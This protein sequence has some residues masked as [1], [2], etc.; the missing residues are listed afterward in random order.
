MLFSLHNF[1]N[2]RS[3]FGL[4]SLIFLA[5]F[6][7]AFGGAPASLAAQSTPGLASRLAKQYRATGAHF[8]RAENLLS[9]QTASREERDAVLAA[10][11]AALLPAVHPALWEYSHSVAAADAFLKLSGEHKI[12]NWMLDPVLYFGG[13]AH[14][15]LRNYVRAAELFARLSPDY[16]RDVYINDRDLPNPD[17]SISTKP[18]IS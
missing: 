8:W 4:R 18:G 7:A 12:H 13:L 17:F 2:R 6:L 11:L 16:K 5:V 3:R 1:E 15:T 10:L 9:A 14:F